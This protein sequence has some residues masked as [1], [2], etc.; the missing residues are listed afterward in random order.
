[1]LA[2]YKTSRKRNYKQVISTLLSA[3]TLLG[4]K[5]PSNFFLHTTP[6]GRRVVRQRKQSELQYVGTPSVRISRRITKI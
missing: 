6:G 5:I 2:A 1:V 3:L 4:S